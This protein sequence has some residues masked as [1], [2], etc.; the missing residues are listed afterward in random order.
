MA[1]QV[2]V[3]G[4]GSRQLRHTEGPSSI[5]MQEAQWRARS[6]LDARHH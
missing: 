6:R 2:F 3:R 1:W 4:Q 5:E